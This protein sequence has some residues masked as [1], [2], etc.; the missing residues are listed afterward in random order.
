MA[1]DICKPSQSME[2]I[3]MRYV[4]YCH[5]NKLNGKK[6]IGITKQ[7]PYTRWRNGEGYKN[8]EHFYRAIKKIWMA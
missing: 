8:N 6:Y 1:K 7:N 4:V 3:V 2:K 5:T